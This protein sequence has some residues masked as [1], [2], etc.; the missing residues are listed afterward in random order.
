MPASAGSAAAAS[1]REKS[2]RLASTSPAAAIGTEARVAERRLVTVLFA[3]LVG[4]TSMSEGRDPEHVRELLTRYFDLAREVVE[5]HGGLVEKFIGDAVM[6]LWGAPVAHEDDAERAVRAALELV[7]AVHA[8]G[9]G[10]E[11]RGAVLTGEAAVT[12]GAIG[13][14]MVAGD[15]VNTASRLQ[16]AAAPG[17]VLVG[18]ATQHA[19][20]IAITFEPVDEQY[21]KG[22]AAP[23]AAWRAVRVVA[24]RRGRGRE[25]RLEA[26]FVGRDAEL[27]LLKDLF[28]ATTRDRRVRLVSITGQ[29]GVGKSRLAW[30]FLKYV[31]G[32]VDAVFWHEGRSPAYGQGLSFWALGEMVRSRADLLETDDEQTTRSKIRATVERFITDEDEGRRVEAALLALLGVGDAPEGGSQG[33]FAAWRTYFE[34][35]TGHGTVALLFEDLHW[36]DSGMLDFIDHMLDW[37]LNVP[38]LIV[39]LARH[40]AAGQPARV[41]RRPAQLPRARPAATRR[42][43]HA[44]A[45]ER[46]RQRPARAGD[47]LDRVACR[48]HPAVRGRDDP[49]AGRR[50]PADRARRRPVRTRA[51]NW[52]TSPSPRRSTR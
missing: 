43:G 15:L 47:P 38:I 29:A 36:A 20:S 44:R 25:D 13:Q 6:A 31:D 16:A 37:S 8:L 32:V 10:L 50:R 49:D 28:H 34:R 24:Q 22:K 46:A 33:M 14:G 26:P 27:R 35:I 9:P 18:E 5:R 11:A 30:E 7:D 4:F 52:G 51:A 45:A 3:D 39:T 40:R 42:R 41:G 1:S 23:V 48:G 19:A 21:L 2:R 17:T 12:L